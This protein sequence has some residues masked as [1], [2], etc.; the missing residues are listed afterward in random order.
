MR[1]AAWESALG[2]AL[3]LFGGAR[4]AAQSTADV[5]ALAEGLDVQDLPAGARILSTGASLIRHIS[6]QVQHRLT[7]ST[8]MRCICT[9]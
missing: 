4:G 3:R 1:A 7:C 8:N 6:G 5:A 9:A 2:H